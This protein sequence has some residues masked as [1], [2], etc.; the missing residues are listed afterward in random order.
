MLTLVYLLLFVAAVVGVN[1]LL[2][3]V[4]GWSFEKAVTFKRFEVIVGFGLNSKTNREVVVSLKVSKT[5]GG[6]GT[7]FWIPFVHIG[8][9]ILE[10]TNID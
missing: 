10:D 8:W 1:L 2:K 3:N 7:S 5:V 6:L 9:E 4:S